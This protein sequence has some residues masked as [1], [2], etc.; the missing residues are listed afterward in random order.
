MATKAGGS[1]FGK[2]GSFEEGFE[3]DALV[4]DDRSLE[5]GIQLG[6]EERLERYVYTGANENIVHK[7]VSGKRIF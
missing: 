2:T 4:I 5:T 7:Y 3:F 1:F 6:L